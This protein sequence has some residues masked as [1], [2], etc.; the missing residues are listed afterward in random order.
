MTTTR[1]LFFNIGTKGFNGASDRLDR[2]KQRALQGL[3]KN[4]RN[5]KTDAHHQN[6]RYLDTLEI[7]YPID[8]VFYSN[9]GEERIQAAS[10]EDL[11]DT[12]REGPTQTMIER[13]FMI[14]LDRPIKEEND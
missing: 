11:M 8:V 6:Q 9:V 1:E 12:L 2:S 5:T 13:G 4:L 7:H 10:P 14:D 3:Y